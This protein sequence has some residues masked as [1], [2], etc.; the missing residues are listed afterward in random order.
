SNS[1]SKVMPRSTVT[2]S[3]LEGP[4]ECRC[5]LMSP[6][7]RWLTTSVE[8]FRALTLLTPATIANGPPGSDCHFTR[9]L[10]LVYGSIRC[11]L[12]VNCAISHLPRDLCLDLSG[13]LLERDDYELGRL[14][15]CKPDDHVDDAEVDVVLRRCFGIH[16][17]EVRVARLLALKRTLA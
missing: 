13:L 7:S 10:N 3:N 1:G 5:V 2:G 16:F 11:V 6:P 4:G 9:N 17:D 8:R 15:R 12:T 14:Q